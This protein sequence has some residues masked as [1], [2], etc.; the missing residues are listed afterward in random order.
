MDYPSPP[1]DAPKHLRYLFVERLPPEL[2][3]R[4]AKGLALQE[5]TL[6]QVLSD[7][8]YRTGAFGKWHLDYSGNGGLRHP[9][10]A[11]FQHYSG[12]PSGG[13]RNYY[14]APAVTNGEIREV[15][16]RLFGA[17]PAGRGDGAQC[18]RERRCRSGPRRPC[19]NILQRIRRG[20]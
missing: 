16:L 11:G 8:G 10:K 2:V 4:N 13:L 14:A 19:L 7:L 12:F 9:N 18:G 15:G 1:A 5:T 6:P 17:D 3:K 20:R